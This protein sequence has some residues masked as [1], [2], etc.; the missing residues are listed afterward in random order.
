MQVSTLNLFS[1]TDTL[2]SPK[3]AS[4][5]VPVSSLE[6]EE[7]RLVWPGSTCL[8]L[9]MPLRLG[10]GRRKPAARSNNDALTNNKPRR[11]ALRFNKNL[12]IAIDTLVFEDRNGK[13]LL[14]EKV[15]TDSPFKLAV[16][17][18]MLQKTQ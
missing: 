3:L 17:R 10:E 12:F 5:T 14:W 13:T 11:I 16:E 2:V 9:G 15:D 18:K 4:V 1:C 7:D 6:E 8:L